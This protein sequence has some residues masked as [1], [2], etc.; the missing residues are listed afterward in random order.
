M[1]LTGILAVR[2]VPYTH[3]DQIKEDPYGTLLADNANGV[4]HD[5]V[6]AYHLDLDVDGDANS[7]VKANLEQRE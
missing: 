3:T 2:W 5:H 1:G 7:F 6:M 4:N